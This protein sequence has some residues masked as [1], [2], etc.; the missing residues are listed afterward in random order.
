MAK[1]GLEATLTLAGKESDKLV[2]VYPA[3]KTGTG[4]SFPAIRLEFGAQ[5][6]GEPNQV[7]PVTCNIAPEIES[8]IFP[9]AQPL[10]M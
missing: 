6:T 10:V 7:Q 9:T 2:L 8:V 3:V 4:Y 5:A 1:A